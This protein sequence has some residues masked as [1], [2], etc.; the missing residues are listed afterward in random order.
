MYATFL[1]FKLYMWRDVLGITFGTILIQFIPF[2]KL[3]IDL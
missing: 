3:F 1:K 2:M